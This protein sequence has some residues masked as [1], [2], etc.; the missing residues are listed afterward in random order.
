METTHAKDVLSI[1]LETYSDV[2]LKD[3]GVY[4]YVE[5]PNFEI[6]LCSISLNGGPVEDYQLAIGDELPQSFIEALTDPNIIK[7][8]HNAQFERV[9]LTKYLY[10]G[11]EKG[12]LDPSQWV[13]TMAHASI[14]GLPSSLEKVGEALGLAEDKKK[15]NTGKALIRYFSVPSK[16]K[17]RTR[18]LPF[19][20]MARW[21][22][23]VEYNIQDVV[24]EVEIENKLSQYPIP[25]IEQKIYAL[26]QRINDRGAGLD[27][28]LVRDITT[29]NDK[30]QASL[31]ERAKEITGLDN[32]N[33][34][35][36][37]LG[38]LKEREN[39]VTSVNKEAVADLLKST[40]DDEVKEMLRI[41]QEMTKTSLKKYDT[42]E[43]AVCSDDR[44][45]G[46]LMYYGANRT[47]RWA[48]RLVQVQNLPRN[49]IEEL[50]DVR[51]LVKAGEF[52]TLDMIYDNVP[53]ILSQL[54]R[55]AFVAPKG[56][57]YVVCDYSAIEA[58]VIAWLAR[59]KWRQDVFKANGDIYCESA[60]QMFN[61]PVVKHGEN[62]HLRQKGKVAE[63]AL[64]YQG[65]I[66]ALKAMGGER[67]GLT[68]SEMTD[69]IAKWRKASPHITAL[70]REVEDCAKKA[71]RTHTP[72]R[73]KN[74][75]IAFLYES[76]ILFIKLPNGRSLAYQGARLEGEGRYTKIKYK[77]MHQERKIWCD[78]DTYGGKLVENIVQ[79]IARDCLAKAMLSLDNVGYEIVFH[80]HDEVVIEVEKDK[81]DAE[82]E[83]IKGIMCMPIQWAPGLIL[84]AEGFTSDYYMKD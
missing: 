39:G 34:N 79:A 58:R 8:A 36:Q 37:L 23:Y 40:K 25:D 71:I 7:E 41:R 15:L 24:T 28:E 70:W 50:S 9:C 60:S 74:R 55:T 78:L 44:I 57:T 43:R 31:L 3:C 21:D 2:S 47:G 77:G 56:R 68:E 5:S 11:F 76:G 35:N 49:N 64:G 16:T 81:A 66:G 19:H 73:L 13:C 69:I 51:E 45:R 33:S 52:E 29:Y 1:D 12:F 42:M 4:K 80:I 10:G 20:D 18:N 65:G 54:I 59:E 22:L 67:M 30:Y 26:D 53:D 75:N 32:P 46:V 48:G 82:Y 17:G 6:L 63:L 27:M 62:G 72:Q 14:L 84:N 38:W 83:L 61:V